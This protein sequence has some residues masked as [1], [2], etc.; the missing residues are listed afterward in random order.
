MQ[1]RTWST[2]LD[3]TSTNLVS[4]RY[5]RSCCHAFNVSMGWLVSGLNA[6]SKSL[7]WKSIIYLRRSLCCLTMNLNNGAVS[8]KVWNIFT[9]LN[10]RLAK[11]TQ[12]SKT[13]NLLREPLCV[14]KRANVS[15]SFQHKILAALSLLWLLTRI[16]ASIL[17]NTD[18]SEAIPC[19]WL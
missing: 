5:A 16:Y 7:T 10:G 14:R 12:E 3:L 11:G 13:P 17:G 4:I 9:R 19:N 15:T 2:S 1:Q 6:L 18:A 8:F